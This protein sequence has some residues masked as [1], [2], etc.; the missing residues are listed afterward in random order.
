MVSQLQ[1]EFMIPQAAIR[2]WGTAGAR[3]RVLGRPE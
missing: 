2:L 1:H 3:R